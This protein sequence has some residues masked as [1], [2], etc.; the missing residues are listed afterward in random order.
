V[1]IAFPGRL[2]VRSVP[3]RLL[4][5]LCAV[6][7]L[8]TG[9]VRAEE[10]DKGLAE[11]LLETLHQKG[12]ISDARYKELKAKA[13]EDKKK[14]EVASPASASATPAVSAEPTWSASWKNGFRVDRSDKAFQL[15]FGGRIQNDYAVIGYTGLPND[16]YDDDGFGAE[17]RRAR[18]FFEGTVYERLTFK[19]QYDF[20]G[21]D[22]DVKDLW[23]GMLFPNQ[24]LEVRVGHQKQ[25][26]SIQGWTS[27]K[28]QVFMEREMMDVFLGSERDD[29]VN[30]LWNPCE[31]AVVQAGA[32]IFAN[33]YGDAPMNGGFGQDQDRYALT[34]RVAGS[35][36]YADEGATVLH[37][38]AGYSHQ[39]RGDDEPLSYATEADAHLANDFID[40]GDI[41]DTRH[42]DLI[43]GEVVSI[44][45]PLMLQSEITG[46]FVTRRNHMSDPQYWGAYGQASYLLTGEHQNYV[47]EEAAFGRLSP[48]KNFNPANGGWGAWEVAARLGFIDTSDEGVKGGE[49]LTF[50]GA[51]NWYLFPNARIMFNYV[52]AKRKNSGDGTNGDM[53]AGE[54]RLQVDF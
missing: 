15:K 23:V 27:S 3:W 14:E 21:G 7:L 30:F 11:E 47:R 46:S 35:P 1:A 17:F 50:T 49:V 31:S 12:D 10:D 43:H 54:M 2:G 33:G 13:A 36:I 28:Y 6:L 32:F 51:V 19:A 18:I 4:T 22:A 34:A 25:P 16:V 9:P 38:G 45:G 20:A 41:L 53:D 5:M 42:V 24:N 44:L 48:T 39:F 26:F 40:T 37:L 52:H 8:W 29:G